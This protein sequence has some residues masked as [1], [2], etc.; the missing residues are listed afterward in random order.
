MGLDEVKL[1]WWHYYLGQRIKKINEQVPK[2]TLLLA[3]WVGFD[4]LVVL[5]GSYF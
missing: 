2:A 3:K 1:L 5:T 4:S